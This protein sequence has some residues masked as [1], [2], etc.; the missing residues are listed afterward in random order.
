[1]LN[2]QI[3]VLNSKF[4]FFFFFLKLIL[5]Y[6]QNKQLD[7]IDIKWQIDKI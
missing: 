4:K 2:E 1:M 6:W 3:E 5:E 7:K